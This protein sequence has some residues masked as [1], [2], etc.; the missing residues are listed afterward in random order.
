MYI[1]CVFE[2]TALKEFG[3]KTNKQNTTNLNIFLCTFVL[4]LSTSF[5]V[6]IIV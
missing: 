3:S 1:D 5:T 4:T 6:V 2:V